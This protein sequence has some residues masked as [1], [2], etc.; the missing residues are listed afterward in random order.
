MEP[1]NQ[2]YDTTKPPVDPKCDK[3]GAPAVIVAPDFALCEEHGRK[4]IAY[5]DQLE[6][7][8]RAGNPQA[9]AERNIA[10]ATITKPSQG[11]DK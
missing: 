4:V 1:S 3:C 8:T 7:G 5:L 2:P 9:I 11:I 10:L 6:R